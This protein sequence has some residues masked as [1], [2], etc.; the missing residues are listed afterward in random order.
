MV[1]ACARAEPVMAFI[2]AM[3]REKRII[4][5]PKTA[6]SVCQQPPTIVTRS[7]LSFGFSTVIGTVP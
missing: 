1:G 7:Q 4:A 5:N 6:M 2:T 3:S